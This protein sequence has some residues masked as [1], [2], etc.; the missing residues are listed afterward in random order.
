MPPPGRDDVVARLVADWDEVAGGGAAV[1]VL[2]GEAGMGKTTVLAAIAEQVG[3]AAVR[4]AGWGPDAPR[5]AVVE[6][7]NRR[8]S[9]GSVI[10]TGPDTEALHAARD[11]LTT[12]RNRC[13]EGPAVI[14]VDDVH[15]LDST[16][17]RVLGMTLHWLTGE[18]VLVVL[19]TR[20]TRD[21]LDAAD[22]FVVVDLPPLDAEQAATVIRDAA[23]TEVADPVVARLVDL[24]GGNPLVLVQL[25]RSLPPAVLAGRAPL[26]DPLPADGILA[27]VVLPRVRALADDTRKLVELLAVAG[28]AEWPAVAHAM[29]DRVEQ[30]LADAEA[31]G[32]VAVVNGTPTLVHRLLGSVVRSGLSGAHERRLHRRLAEAPELHEPI[33][34]THLAASTVG[35]DPDL[36]DRMAALADRL[37]AN[38]DHE[39]AGHL[40]EQAAALVPS[41]PRADRMRLAAAVALIDGG[42]VTAARSLAEALLDSEDGE[43]RAEAIRRTAMLD[44]LHGDPI[45]AW[46]RLQA[47]ADRT[48][49]D[50]EAR[51]RAAVSLPLGMLGLTRQIE[52]QA[53][54]AAALAEPGSATH[55]VVLATLAHAQL[56]HR[57]GDVGGLPEALESAPP[58]REILEEDPVFGLHV[59]RA[60]ALA[61]RHRAAERILA[62]LRADGAGGPSLA[63]TLGALA[64]SRFRTCRWGEAEGLLSEAIATSMTM[65][66]QAF[67]TFWLA[68]RSRTRALM[69]NTT[70]AGS[71]LELGLSIATDRQLVGARYF[72]SASAGFVHAIAGHVEAAVAAW[73]ECLL[74]EELGGDLSPTLARWRPELAELYLALGRRDDARAL[75][76]HLSGI[77]AEPTATRW[78]KGVAARCRALLAD[79]DAVAMVEL[80]DAVSILDPDVD[81]FDHARALRH[82]SV[83]A[84]RMGEDHRAARDARRAT[85]LLQQL[86]AAG[87]PM[88]GLG[89]PTATVQLT[90]VESDVMALVAQ[91]RTNQQI[92]TA[93]SLSPKTVAN[94]L[95]RIYKR[96]GVGSR[97][98]ALQKLG[99]TDGSP[100]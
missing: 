35:P 89:R 96:L 47:E 31:E 46:Q 29:A 13:T 17:R 49:P 67:A 1:R 64:E 43:V 80:D 53:G 60:F 65:G 18:P 75:A 82:R 9:G 56:A 95:Y 11:L 41:G 4:V 51:A 26:P 54:R 27:G 39:R 74:F 59:G 45:A 71:D 20:P 42:A 100:G 97:I 24:A 50:T 21:G 90:P 66:L 52:E 76:D 36:A 70:G 63:L 3:H 12:I 69:G 87:W 30:A 14:L 38:G 23:A 33:R 19:A 16:S 78:T 92:A 6:D 58:W 98:E 73:E 2:R 86:G 91:G 48:D 79:D 40:R 55:V 84:A 81:R 10:I 62:A 44:A 28:D 72:L 93:L 34:L 32:L 5:M 99:A 94:H 85:F 7:L 77:A 22:G 8:L 83:L 25:P 68:V 61:E 57:E 88:E 15:D 37:V